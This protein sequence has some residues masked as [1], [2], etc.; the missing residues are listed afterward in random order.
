MNVKITALHFK[1]DKKL[2]EF[3]HEKLSKVE[4]LSDSIIGADVIL[5]IEN[6]EKSENKIAEIK[7]KIKGADLHAEKVGS[8]FEAATDLAIEAIRKQLTKSKEKMRE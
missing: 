2:E 3:I 6:T 1:A 4:K 5:K 8:S 7:L